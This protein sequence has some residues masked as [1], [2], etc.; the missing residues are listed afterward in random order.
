MRTGDLAT[1]ES[2]R[3]KASAYAKFVQEKQVLSELIEEE[4]REKQN[5][6][7]EAMAK[8][9]QIEEDRKAAIRL[10]QFDSEELG[11]PAAGSHHAPA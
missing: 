4:E 3:I 11:K 5:Q 7:N 9:L 8:E 1:R 10:E 6:W 2:Q